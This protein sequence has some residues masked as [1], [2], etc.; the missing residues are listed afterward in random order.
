M[1]DFTIARHNLRQYRGRVV[2][3]AL[4]VVSG[5]VVSLVCIGLVGRAATSVQSSINEGVALRTVELQ[6]D[7]GRADIKP[8]RGP[9]VSTLRSTAH[10]TA[11]E[12]WL[13]A[14]FGIKTAEIGG[15]LLYATPAR[16]SSLP[17]IVRST[18]GN[19]FPLGEGEAVLPQRV[20]GETFDS[21][22]GKRVP[23]NY[24]RKTGEGKGEAATDQITVVAL[25]DP[26]Y[27][28]DGPS[29]AY[30]DSRQLVRWAAARAGVPADQ[31]ID[32]IGYRKAYAIVD[33]STNVA[34]VVTALRADGYSAA[35]LQERLTALPG[36]LRALRTL[37]VVVLILLLVYG[38]VA[39]VAIS[40]SFMKSRTHEIGLLNAVGF[41]PNRILRVLLLELLIVGGTAGLLGAV[42]GGVATAV[43][44]AAAGGH[45][46]FGIVMPKGIAWPEWF[47][48]VVILLAP[49][50]TV[51]LGGLVPAWR[52]AQLQPDLALRDQG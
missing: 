9:N 13:Q 10:V 15:A 27:A 2:A 1:A 41:R 50:L 26:K 48:T 24:T 23:V 47:W 42:L 36:E 4:A 52:V 18:R 6:E 21:L 12:P 31:Y 33:T 39:G 8:L 20:Q 37:G 51:T 49:A 25:Y 7:A 30:T 35:T 28:L 22:L 34:A 43:I 19:V 32:T 45:E 38:A 3:L 29:A 14:S 16:P 46:L 11:V 5:S 17:P 40:G 44:G